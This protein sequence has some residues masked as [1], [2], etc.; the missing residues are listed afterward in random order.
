MHQSLY[1]A[2]TLFAILVCIYPESFKLLHAKKKIDIREDRPNLPGIALHILTIIIPY[3]VALFSLISLA[4]KGIYSYTYLSSQGRAL[5]H[6]VTL[7]SLS[8][9][10]LAYYLSLSHLYPLTRLITCLAI[11]VW[12]IHAYDF[13]WSLSSLAVRGTG[14][15]TLSLISLSV[16]SAILF[17]LHEKHGVFRFSRTWGTR[18]LAFLLLI[19]IYVTAAKGMINSGFFQAMELYDQGL[20]PDPNIGNPFWL[21]SKV[22]VFWLFLPIIDRRGYSVPLRLD[23]RVIVW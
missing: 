3:S 2:L 12:S 18:R 7:F 13:V 16:T 22:T 19:L 9:S 5:C 4:T 21:V 14:S 6:S 20:G 11:S 8:S 15:V 23:P 1:T 10:F 17:F